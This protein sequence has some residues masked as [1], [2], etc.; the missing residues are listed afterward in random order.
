[1][2][3]KKEKI[4]DLKFVTKIEFDCWHC[5]EKVTTKPYMLCH[6]EDEKL[7]I[8]YASGIFCS[9]ACLLGFLAE[10]VNHRSDV[11][12]Q[13]TFRLNKELGHKDVLDDFKIAPSRFS[14]KRFGGPLSIEEF[15]K[16]QS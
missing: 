2:F 14:L 3:E 11:T 1:M 15:R 16:Y 10:H 5:C 4:S 13:L 9:N 8:Y 12:R 6:S 7:R